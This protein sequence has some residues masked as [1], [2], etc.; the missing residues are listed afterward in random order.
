MFKSHNFGRVGMVVVSNTLVGSIKVVGKN[1]RIH[2]RG[3]EHGRF[4]FGGSTIV[5]LFEKGRVTFDPDLLMNS[6]MRVE[7]LV[8]ARSRIG[9]ARQQT[10]ISSHR[11]L[12][13]ALR[14]EPKLRRKEAMS[15]NSQRTKV[16]MSQ[17][18]PFDFEQDMP[19][20]EYTEDLT[21]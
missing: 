17:W 6:K 21:A 12:V 8:K 14:K 3:E 1:K 13:I 11:D 18:E 10:P 2:Y 9:I 16:D 19:K 7:T 4:Q 5:L 15:N 20:T